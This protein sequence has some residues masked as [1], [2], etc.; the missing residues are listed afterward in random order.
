MD[1]DLSATSEALR[2]RLQSFFDQQV[3]PRHRGWLE[4]T[5]QA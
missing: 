3:L 1:F 5:A 4:H 2:K